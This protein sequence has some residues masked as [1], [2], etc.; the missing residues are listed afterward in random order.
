MSDLNTKLKTLYD[1]RNKFKYAFISLFY[2]YSYEFYEF[3]EKGRL[4]EYLKFL[5]SE[6]VKCES[7]SESDYSSD[8]SLIELSD[9][10]PILNNPFSNEI[11]ILVKNPDILD[12][13]KPD[14]NYSWHI[15]LPVC[16]MIYFNRDL[17]KVMLYVCESSMKSSMIEA[18][19]E[20]D[21][22]PVY[23]VEQCIYNQL[24]YVGS[25]KVEK[26]DEVYKTF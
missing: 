3:Y 21:Y 11:F 7:L 19:L 4:I 17:K 10:F 12:I 24:K 25:F 23:F 13:S 18:K 15:S 20:G 2:N 22:I 1:L 9:Y 8:F 6:F 5:W 14:I 16:F 26:L